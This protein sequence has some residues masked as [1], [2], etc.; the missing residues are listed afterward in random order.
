MIPLITADPQLHR[1][2]F[3]S[4][5]EQTLFELLFEPVKSQVILDT[6]GNIQDIHNLSGVEFNENESISSLYYY[7]S[8]LA[9]T[10]NFEYLPSQLD[11]ARL[12]CNT[13]YGSIECGKLPTELRYFNV[14]DNKLGGRLELCDLPHRILY[15]CVSRNRISGTLSFENLP[16]SLYA[17]DVGMNLFE[18]S[19]DMRCIRL[20]LVSCHGKNIPN[21][22]WERDFTPVQGRLAVMFAKNNFEGDIL[23]QSIK[24]VADL[25]SFTRNTLCAMAVDTSGNNVHLARRRTKRTCDA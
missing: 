9:G 21:T 1:A 2:D 16:A 20:N 5:S 23:L 10:I 18:G 12:S 3:H 22:A 8:R 14:Y 7:S 11:R 19:L 25:A 15:L 24:K 4:L 13:L 6:D 17:L